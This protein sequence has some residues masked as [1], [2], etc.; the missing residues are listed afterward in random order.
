[1]RGGLQRAGRLGI[2]GPVGGDDLDVLI[3]G[4]VI[5]SPDYGRVERG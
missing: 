5:R 2:D 4:F 3:I 1:V